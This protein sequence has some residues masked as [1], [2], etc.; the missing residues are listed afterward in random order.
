MNARLPALLPSERPHC[1]RCDCRM[2]FQRVERGLIGY[3]NRVFE[4]R[5]CF[6]VKTVAVADTP[7]RP[8]QPK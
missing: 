5:R 6:A 2:D 7:I 4:C 3:Q 8:A 1:S